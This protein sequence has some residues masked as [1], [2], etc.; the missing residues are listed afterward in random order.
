MSVFDEGTVTDRDQRDNVSGSLISSERVAGTDVY[1][2]DGDKLG[3]IDNV[4]IDKKSGQVRYAVMSFGGFLGIGEKYH[5]LP[6]DGLDYDTNRGGYVVN[7]TR[8]SLEAAPSYD[9]DE[10]DNFD[11]DNQGN[12]I[13]GYYEKV[14]G[15]F[16]PDRQSRH[17]G[18]RGMSG[19]TG[20]VGRGTA[21]GA[22]GSELPTNA[23]R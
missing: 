23:T 4:M 5:Q 1:N 7:L 21:G 19:Q 6:W 13:E 18:S 3:T 11:Y 14:E 22:Y 12:S 10:V 9:R 2:A 17:S 15:F 20:D 8:E 16:S